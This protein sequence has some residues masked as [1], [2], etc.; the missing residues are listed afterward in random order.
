MEQF[1]THQVAGVAVVSCTM[2][3]AV[4]RVDGYE[5]KFINRAEALKM[6]GSENDRLRNYEIEER[7]ALEYDGRWVISEWCPFN[8]RFCSLGYFVGYPHPPMEGE[9]AQPPETNVPWNEFD[10]ERI[11]THEELN[12]RAKKHLMDERWL[13]LAELGERADDDDE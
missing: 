10:P 7:L 12:K 4:V 5:V 13:F 6:I 8:G 1:I 3:L 11:P 9:S 2:F